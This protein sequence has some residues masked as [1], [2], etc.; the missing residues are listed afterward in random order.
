MN[1]D[2]SAFPGEALAMKAVKCSCGYVATGETAD[3]LLA[4]V[5]E[6]ID[7]EHGRTRAARK[8][9]NEKGETCSTP[10]YTS[11]AGRS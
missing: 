11:S 3:E 2:R 9:V 5:E 1:D 7:A 10:S 4:D 6:H 8:P